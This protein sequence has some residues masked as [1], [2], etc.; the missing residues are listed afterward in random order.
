MKRTK[1]TISMLLA[2]LIVVGMIPMAAISAFA[3]DM[4][5]ATGLHIY[6]PNTDSLVTGGTVSLNRYENIM[7]EAR[8]CNGDGSYDM[9]MTQSWRSDS[10]SVASVDELG[11]VMARNSGTATVTV[12][13]EDYN[14]EVYTASFTVKVGGAA[15]DTSEAMIRDRDWNDV[16][17]GEYTVK[18]DDYV[19]LYFWYVDAMG[20]NEMEAYEGDGLVWSSDNPDVVSIS[21]E[22]KPYAAGEG[23]AVITGSYT[24]SNGYS[25]SAST[26]VVVE[27]YADDEVV[28]IEIRDDMNQI[29][30][31]SWSEVNVGESSTYT[32]WAAYGNDDMAEISDAKW[33]I[34]DN[35]Y[36]TLDENGTVTAKK[37][38]T[39]YIY[40]NYTDTNGRV[41]SAYTQIRI[42]DPNFVAVDHIII[43][44]VQGGDWSDN[45]F[46]A[47]IGYHN[48]FT[49]WAVYE[50][51]TMEE[52]TGSFSSDNESIIAANNDGNIYAKAEG[53]ATVTATYLETDT[54]TYYRATMTV[55]GT[56]EDAITPAGITNIAIKDIE[57]PRP[58]SIPDYTYS[59]SS[60]S[61]FP[62]AWSP[63]CRNGMIWIDSEGFVF[64]AETDIVEEGAGYRLNIYLKA[65]QGYYFDYENASFTVTVNGVE[66]TEILQPGGYDKSGYICISVPAMTAEYGIIDSVSVDGLTYPVVGEAADFEAVVPK[67]ANYTVKAPANK[68][69]AINGI[70][71]YDITDGAFLSEGDVF[72]LDHLYYPYV[73]LCPNTGYR[74]ATND[75]GTTAVKAS[76]ENFVGKFA[77]TT[78]SS[79]SAAEQIC[80]ATSYKAGGAYY[81][82]VIEPIVKKTITCTN[83]TA[84]NEAGEIV[85]EALA[86]EKIKLVATAPVYVG[87]P[88]LGFNVYADEYVEL[89]TDF[90]VAYFTMPDCE[91]SVGAEY[92]AYELASVNVSIDAPIL[93]TALDFTPETEDYFSN[94]WSD[95]DIIYPYTFAS[96]TG[97]DFE[98]VGG[99]MWFDNTYGLDYPMSEGNVFYEDGVYNLCIYIKAEPGFSL[100]NLSYAYI[101]NYGSAEILDA[102]G[103]YKLLR[104]KNVTPK[105]EYSVTAN[106]GIVYN[107]LEEVT[108]AIEGTFLRLVLNQAED[109]MRTFSHWELSDGTIVYDR[110]YYFDMPAEDLEFT[111]VYNDIPVSDCNFN[112]DF[113]YV[114]N[115]GYNLSISG[116]MDG[117]SIAHGITSD[118]YG[119]PLDYVLY[120]INVD[121]Y[122]NAVHQKISSGYEYAIDVE[123]TP[124]DY[125]CIDEDILLENATITVNGE[126]Y[127]AV[128]CTLT[129][130][131][132]ILSFNIGAPASVIYSPVWVNGGTAYWNGRAVSEA[133]AGAVIYLEPDFDSLMVG[134]QFASW[135]VDFGG[136]TVE[137][138]EYGSDYFVMSDEAVC[139]TAKAKG[140]IYNIYISDI[141]IPVAGESP[142]Y[143]ATVYP[144]DG[145]DIILRS[146]YGWINGVSW[147]ESIDQYSSVKLDP[148]TA[149]FEEGKAYHVNF[150][151][152]ALE[153]YWFPVNEEGAPTVQAFV[154]GTY[155]SVAMY[156]EDGSRT[157]S[158]SIEFTVPKA[159]SITVEGGNAYDPRSNPSGA[160]TGGDGDPIY[161][162]Y[163]GTYVKVV[164]DIPAGYEFSHW[165]I[166]EGAFKIDE[167]SLKNST[168][169]FDMPDSDVVLRAVYVKAYNV[170]FCFTP[171]NPTFGYSV[172]ENGYATEPEEPAQDGMV[173]AGWY[174]AD[175]EKF[176][177]NTPITE[178]I[179]LIAKFVMAGDLDGS[180]SLNATDINI[181][182]R[183]LSGMLNA[184]DEQFLACDLNGDGAINGADANILTRV[185]AGKI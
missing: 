2:I 27:P 103:E 6:N 107:D 87:Q 138:D 91:V 147:W 122:F 16:T 99:V 100:D 32:V 1:K 167:D 81:A 84:Y 18:I 115:D 40:C 126:T 105:R 154:N 52:V 3:V 79:I 151:I 68:T 33:E 51:G 164:A 144:E 125:Y 166:V 185:V 108:T 8:I 66:V 143:T 37:M 95:D 132:A 155:A 45:T 106:G 15:T 149:V 76:V 129:N 64:D 97:T 12:T 88:F 19:E 159:Y 57:T 121:T 85:T 110:E 157:V 74:F 44:D 56:T 128:K 30:S 71:W 179:E 90:D 112:L 96:F 77:S 114:G 169:W 120:G 139:V 23:R 168:F 24:D 59:F 31:G 60:L 101:E 94:S 46:T 145:Y 35:G 86:G 170:N 136:V 62:F 173:F 124:D 178:D 152:E 73:Y 119:N 28:Y 34:V 150:C 111:A 153:E 82:N 67:D 42:I 9:P 13:C 26:T 183:I 158:V 131:G 182:R 181:I 161:S 55:E 80:L 65:Q 41:H 163:P 146:D 78:M 123:I 69:T 137:A 11:N 22:G 104:I 47:P 98:V 92:G 133:P 48:A 184:T 142:D 160:P 177:F 21:E 93:G 102:Y 17:G 117:A 89:T 165:E 175:G 75:D 20:G 135:A 148:E 174:T 140:A 63:D 10:Q 4:D 29:V 141:D 70:E 109:D 113:F 134:Q 116:D 172:I 176:D 36:L 72:E 7:L 54:W 83:C 171:G 156:G 162:A 49:I 5:T 61:Y 127:G 130:T 50:D 43:C 25:Y 118:I 39:T 14:G 180:G 58:G 53:S 38:G